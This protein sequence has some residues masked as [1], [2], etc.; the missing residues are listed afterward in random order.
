[1][2]VLQDS[3]A[4]VL[5]NRYWHMGTKIKHAINEKHIL[6]AS[7]FNAIT[8]VKAAI[9]TDI[10]RIFFTPTFHTLPNTCLFSFLAMAWATAMQTAASITGSPI[11]VIG[12][13]NLSIPNT[14]P[15]VRFQSSHELRK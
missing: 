6:T 15:N 8:N 1:M 10:K 12:L 9:R 13:K 14:A 4:D 5:P 2:P 11:A 7:K 3:I